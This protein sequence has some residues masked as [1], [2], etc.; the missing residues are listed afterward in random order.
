M[1]R[2]LRMNVDADASGARR[3]LDSAARAV[4][5]LG[6]ETRR[7]Q[8]EFREASREAGK[9]DRKLLETQAAAAA[10]GREFAKTQD[11]SLVAQIA[12]H[13][14]AAAEIKKIQASIVGDSGKRAKE[15]AA[16]WKKA[17]KELTDLGG[18][19]AGLLGEGV[20]LLGT[21][22]KHPGVAAAAGAVAIPAAI[23]IGAITGGAI[24]A[25]VGGGVAGLTVAGA[26]AQSK[27]VHRAWSIEIEGIK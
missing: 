4:D 27:A 7:L 25:G 13:N 9:L 10:L 20:P 6:D 17:F 11:K 18:A 1:A 12:A 22:A 21:I 3:G 2:D 8:R 26:A 19:G 23:G 24:G 5:H 16:A 15:S 14:K